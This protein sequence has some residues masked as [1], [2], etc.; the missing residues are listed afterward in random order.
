ML[1]DHEIT[2]AVEAGHIGVTPWD[3]KLV[4]PASL[5]VR[6]GDEIKERVEGPHGW[7]TVVHHC[8]FELRP[9]QFV[10][11]QTLETI[12]VPA[13]LAVHLGGKSS[14]GRLGLVV[15]STA[16]FIDPGFTGQITLELSN[17]GP[18]PIPLR[19][20]RS[21]GQLFFW[22]L[23]SSAKRPYGSPGLGSHY[24]GQRGATMSRFTPDYELL[25]AR[26]G[27]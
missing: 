1:P 23:T 18:E 14:W 25:G 17:V 24:Q 20:G 4:Q 3:P 12:T 13:Y 5:D 10:L 6:L 2:A 21:Y 22:L 27:E 15:H 8:P 9:G 19:Q 11:G 7:E 16:G 26:N